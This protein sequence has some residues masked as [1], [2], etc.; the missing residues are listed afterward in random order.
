[1]KETVIFNGENY[2]E[3]ERTTMFYLKGKLL[4]FV[5]TESEPVEQTEKKQWREADTK[6]RGK[7]G[8]RVHPKYYEELRSAGNTA[9]EQ[10][11]AIQQIAESNKTNKRQSVMAN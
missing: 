4:S 11:E 8:E 10:W 9:K 5:L 2:D 7:I 6:A 3:W 1:M